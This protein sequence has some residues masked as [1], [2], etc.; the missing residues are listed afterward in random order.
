MAPPGPERARWG[1]H[2]HAAEPSAVPPRIGGL[3]GRGRSSRAPRSRRSRL[4]LPSEWGAWRAALRLT[5]AEQRPIVA[6][7]SAEPVQRRQPAHKEHPM[8]A[9]TIVLTAIIASCVSSL[10]TI[11][12]ALLVLAPSI[13]AAPDLQA[14]QPLVRA[15][16]FEL[17]DAD[18]TV[19]AFLSTA[20]DVAGLAIGDPSTSGAALLAV[21]P[22]GTPLLRMQRS[23]GQA[24][25]TISVTPDDVASVGLGAVSG[26]A[27][28]LRAGSSGSSAIRVQDDL[29]HPRAEFGVGADGTS[30]GRLQ[31]ETGQAIWQAP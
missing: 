13:R 22:V 31:D 5:A 21:G 24:T 26:R 25:A 1:P 29:Q 14:T 7:S 19:R 2:W 8:R 9:R 6:A 12:V 15:E 28:L 10:V 3:G 20:G 27:M 18:G 4:L 30:F 23:G 17:V 11:A 16:R